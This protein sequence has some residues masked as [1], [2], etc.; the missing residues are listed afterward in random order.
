MAIELGCYKAWRLGSKNKLV[1]S[2]GGWEAI[3]PGSLK[4]QLDTDIHRV[5]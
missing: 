1:Y 2:L 5:T 3:K 4:H